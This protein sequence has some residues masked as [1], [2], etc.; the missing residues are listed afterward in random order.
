MPITITL[1]LSPETLAEGSRAHRDLQARLF[2]RVFL[3]LFRIVT[4]VVGY[5]W[6]VHRDTMLFGLALMLFG[7]YPFVQPFINRW[8][9]ERRFRQH[10]ELYEVSTWTFDDA[11]VSSSADSAS[12]S[13]HWKSMTAIASV[14]G[15]IM[16]YAFPSVYNW[17]PASCFKS[18][19]QVREII[20][21]A[22]AGG[23]TSHRNV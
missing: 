4:V 13:A 7:V 12:S 21:M 9:I 5:H 3:N 14:R 1:N 8:R 17:F 19:E 16:L 23:I 10:P 22:V 11:G 18:P 2:F 15:G 20:D 6:F